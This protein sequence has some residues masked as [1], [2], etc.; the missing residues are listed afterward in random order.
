M[1]LKVLYTQI[2]DIAKKKKYSGKYIEINTF[3]GNKK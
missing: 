1:A 2:K 3:I